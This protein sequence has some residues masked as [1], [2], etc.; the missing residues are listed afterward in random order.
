MTLDWPIKT[1]IKFPKALRVIKKFR[2][3]AAVVPKTAEKKRLA[4][5]CSLAAM[6]DLG[7]GCQPLS[8]EELTG[9]EISNIAQ[10]I[11]NRDQT[12]T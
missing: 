6:T 11:Q 2:P 8:E 10:D 7:T 9:S 4:V 3:L 5:T 12:E 1:D